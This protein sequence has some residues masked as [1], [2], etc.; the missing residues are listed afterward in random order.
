[1]I[2]REKHKELSSSFF[3]KKVLILYGARQVGKTT[4]ARQVVQEK[5]QPFLWFN[6]DELDTK[7]ILENTNS[8]KLKALFGNYKIIVI[9]EAQRIEN[10]G[11]TL[12]IA[13]DNFP[14][15]QVIATGS[16]S[17]DLANK[18]NEPLTGRKKEIHIYP[19][20]V[21]E[22]TQHYGIIQE[23]RLLQTRL[24]YGSYPEIVLAEEERKEK[25]L[26]LTNSYLYKDIYAIEGLKKTSVFTKILSALA[27][28][29]G[30]EVSYNEISKLVG[31]NNET[32]GRYID[33]L[34]QAFVVFRLPAYSRNV[35]TELRK[36]KKIYFYDNGLR[37]AIINNFVP[38]ENRTDIGGLW[39]NFIIS[40]RMKWLER[41]NLYRFTHF[42]RTTQQQE[43][44]Y[45]EEYD[46]GFDLAEIKWNE[47]RKWKIP[48]SFSDQY[49]IHSS[50]IVNKENYMDWLL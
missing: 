34:E 44:D 9:D 41:M 48:K 18:V 3:K 33:L 35:R 2:Q 23:K 47:K 1:M 19:F 17:F 22:L 13:I 31:I 24:I 36:S 43:I 26:D 12:K 14:D 37:N 50:T 15:I 16:S 21:N 49:S 10:I 45:L 6:G 8:D 28:Q 7:A 40:E 25:L 32:V 42:W 27:L 29:I 39:E 4:L 11:L 20:S 38:I 5:K 30:S 46:G